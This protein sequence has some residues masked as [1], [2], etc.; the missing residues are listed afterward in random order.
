MEHRD[1]VALER[2]QVLVDAV[3]LQVGV[4]DVELA[5]QQTQQVEEPPA[6]RRAVGCGHDVADVEQ[7]RSCGRGRRRRYRPPLAERARRELGAPARHEA[8]PVR[9]HEPHRVGGGGAVL[10]VVH[11][12]ARLVDRLPARIPRLEREIDVLVVAGR[13]ALL[14]DADAIEDR[15]LDQETGG[16]AEVDLAA[17]VERGALRVLRSARARARCLRGRPRCQPPGG[18]RPDRPDARRRDRCSARRRRWPR[19]CR[20]SRR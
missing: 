9:F 2:A 12:H 13:E 8:R 1:A 7:G 16:R 3:V 15:A 14:E 20:A 10:V 4:R 6:A 17:L 18:D 5:R 19:A 11:R